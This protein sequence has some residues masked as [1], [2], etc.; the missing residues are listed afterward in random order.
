MKFT[1]SFTEYCRFEVVYRGTSTSTKVTRLTEDTEYRFRIC[2]INGAGQGTFS[3]LYKFNT[4]KSPPP[5]VKGRSLLIICNLFS[6]PNK[7]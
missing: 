4:S 3:D 2:A 1:R 5:Q 6:I 7:I